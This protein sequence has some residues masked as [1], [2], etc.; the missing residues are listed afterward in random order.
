MKFK[1]KGKFSRS[2][3]QER[4]CFPT[5][6]SSGL[7]DTKVTQDAKVFASCFS[8]PS[9]PGICWLQVHGLKEKGWCDYTEKTTTI[10]IQIPL[11]WNARICLWVSVSASHIWMVFSCDFVS[12][13]LSTVRTL[14]HCR[15]RAW[16]LFHAHSLR[17]P[18][19]L[20]GMLMDSVLD[21]PVKEWN[22]NFADRTLSVSAMSANLGE[23]NIDQALYS[24]CT[25]LYE[26][27]PGSPCHGLPKIICSIRNAQVLLASTEQQ[28][29]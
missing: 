17:G 2:R 3:N 12:F 10:K 15:F 24:T 23:D 4:N 25:I 14:H 6:K 9:E 27:T 26:Y 7:N 20:M 8:C 5:F 11:N 29:N 1:D 13:I 28:Q 21:S 22:F 19:F 18:S 16:A